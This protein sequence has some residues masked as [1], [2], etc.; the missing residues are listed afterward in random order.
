LSVLGY[1][2]TG[3]KYSDSRLFESLVHFAGVPR[4]QS[5]HQVINGR[6]CDMITQWVQI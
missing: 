6:K 5:H 3:L 2:V 4:F 1:D